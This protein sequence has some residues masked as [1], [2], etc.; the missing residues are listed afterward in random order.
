[1]VAEN[2]LAIG[3]G[4]EVPDFVYRWPFRESLVVMRPKSLTAM[5]VTEEEACGGES[6]Q[7]IGSRRTRP[8]AGPAQPQER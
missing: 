6:A 3:R 4:H 5:P 8:A 2:A 1:M 7:P